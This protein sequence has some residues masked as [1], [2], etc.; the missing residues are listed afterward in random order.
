[1]HLLADLIPISGRELKR[2]LFAQFSQ[3]RGL[4]PRAEDCPKSDKVRVGAAV[5]L[6]VGM[7][8]TKKPAGCGT[9]ILLDSVDI[10]ASGVKPVSRVTFGIFIR[11]GRLP[12]AN[13]V[14]REE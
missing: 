4:H 8:A 14:L 5:G 7:V 10:I 3:G 1:M 6:D 9:G 12:I 11:Q 13:W 2:V